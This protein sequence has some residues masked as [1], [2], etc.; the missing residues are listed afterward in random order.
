MQDKIVRAITR[1]GQIK[2]SAVY[3]KNMVQTAR[4]IHGTMPVATA[5]L[6]RTLTAA[7]I[8]GAELKD[9]DGSVTVQIKGDG[10]VGTILAVSDSFGNTRGYLQ[11][12]A[13]E[14]PLKP[15]GKLDVSGA[16]GTGYLTVIKD[17]GMKEPFHGT[18]KLESGEIAEDITNY[19][20]SSEQI[21]SAC[22]LGVLVDVD[23]SVKQAGGYVVQ[24]M[25]GASDKD[26]DTLESTLANIPSVTTMLESGK[27]IHDII[28]DVLAGFDVDILE[29]S[30]ISYK[31]NCSD[32]KVIGA[33]VSLGET[34]LTNLIEEKE[35]M[36][37][38]C[39]FC[40]KIYNFS[41]ETLRDI[42]KNA[43]N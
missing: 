11:N 25:P 10:P 16:V 13:V 31:C 14:L 38:T 9:D 33:L 8:L 42:L 32:N 22:A 27:T 6:G 28:H 18:V 43:L 2:I 21:P 37:V 30:E 7:S 23:L 3:T 41:R 24:L 20:A 36:E 15:N 39:Q 34:E 17:I 1:N 26:I 40:D 12:P 19:F 4:Q 35:K 5:A 29:E